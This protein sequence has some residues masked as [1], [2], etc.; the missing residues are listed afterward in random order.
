[1][2]ID[3]PGE[4]TGKREAFCMKTGPLPMKRIRVGERDRRPG[5][6]ASCRIYR[7]RHLI[8]KDI[9]IKKN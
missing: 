2:K 7:E 5:V 6:F 4:I 1:M 3:F 9:L 8:E